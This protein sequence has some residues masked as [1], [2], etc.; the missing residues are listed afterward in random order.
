MRR[1]AGFLLAALFLSLSVSAQRGGNRIRPNYT[2]VTVIVRFPHGESVK[3]GVRVELLSPGGVRVNTAYTNEDG[4]ATLNMVPAGLSYVLRV[5][6]ENIAPAMQ[7]LM[8]EAG[9]TSHSEWIEVGP[10]RSA[11]PTSAHGSVAVVDLNV[12]SDARK[13]LEKGNSLAGHNQWTEA[14]E[15]YQK[16]IELYPKYATAYNNLGSARMNL[17]DA[18]GAKEAYQH[19]VALND[20]YANA[21]MNLAH[22]QHESGDAQGAEQSLLKA[23]TTDPKNV[24]ALADLA[25][26]E[27]QLQKFDATQDYVRKANALP[28]QGYALI[29]VL[30]AYAYQ[31]QNKPTEALAEYKLYLQEDPKGVMAEKVRATIENME[32]PR[33]TP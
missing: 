21:W 18:A 1:R 31:Q 4:S 8:I 15:H 25:Q 22:L 28:H 33:P 9:E 23:L 32:K 11:S 30:G 19:A 2:D 27:L 12:P 5:S 24:Q 3:S 26:V 13:E 10:R 6:G 14:A 16:A 20:K 17:H 29:H 7:E